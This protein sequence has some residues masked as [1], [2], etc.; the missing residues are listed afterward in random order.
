MISV[1]NDLLVPRLKAPCPTS[2]ETFLFANFSRI[3]WLSDYHLCYGIDYMSR[4][5]IFISELEDNSRST[6]SNTRSFVSLFIYEAF[7]VKK[8]Y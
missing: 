7:D 3:F 5:F 4:V 6:Y 2:T 8:Y 1:M